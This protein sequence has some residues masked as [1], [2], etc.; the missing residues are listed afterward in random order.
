MLVITE[1]AETPPQPRE[2][3]GPIPRWVL[4]IAIVLVI[5]VVLGTQA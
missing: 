3:S 2:P 5:I 1:V 4:I